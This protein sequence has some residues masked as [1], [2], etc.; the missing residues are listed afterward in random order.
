MKATVNGFGESHVQLKEWE[1]RS[2]IYIHRW[3]STHHPLADKSDFYD[4]RLRT[5]GPDWSYDDT[6]PQFTTDAWYVTSDLM[7]CSKFMLTTQQE[8]ERMG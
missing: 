7:Y 1:I 8:S 5:F 2:D 3:Y 6:F 4:Y